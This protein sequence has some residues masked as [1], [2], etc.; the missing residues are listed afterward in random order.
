[1]MQR[2]RMPAGWLPWAG[3]PENY[4]LSMAE[5]VH[6]GTMD[7]EIAGTL[8]AAVD[9][10][11]SFLTV[12]VPQNAGKTTVASAVLAL[13]P[14]DVDLHFAMGEPSELEQLAQAQAGGYI[15]VGEFSR[16]PMPSYI[17]GDAVRQVFTTLR[18]GYSLQTSLL[19]PGVA[20]AVRVITEGNGVPDE[21]ASALKLVVYIEVFG[22]NRG[23][24]VRRVTEVYELD[25]VEGGLPAGRTLF[26]WQRD[27]DRFE[28]LSE[29]QQF[30]L[31]RDDLARRREVIG[32]LAAS[33]RTSTADV[34]EA[35]AAFRAG[36]SV[37]P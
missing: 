11:L 17:W 2:G 23:D 29:P 1:M 37:R 15:V 3:A 32:A 25:R 33:G 27:G 34:A 22:T 5:L 18:Y 31:D 4:K 26:R 8:W 19:A 7:A 36:S 16:A 12:A 10:Q 14:P 6:N 20:P 9:E 28:K 30:G 24:I 13:R 21:D 35:V